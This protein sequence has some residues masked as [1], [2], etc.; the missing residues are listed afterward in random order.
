MAK[1][2]REFMTHR[3]PPE[4]IWMER[5]ESAG[6]FEGFAD[7]F[8]RATGRSVLQAAGVTDPP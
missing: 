4:H 5:D 8:Q 7:R 2:I 6:G 3:E 1:K